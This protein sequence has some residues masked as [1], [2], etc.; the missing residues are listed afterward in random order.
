MN[1]DAFLQAFNRLGLAQWEGIEEDLAWGH[2][3]CLMGLAR[4]STDG[5][6]YIYRAPVLPGRLSPTRVQLLV[7]TSSSPLP[8]LSD[9]AS[10][11]DDLADPV[12]CEP[13][14]LISLDTSRGRS[15]NRELHHPCYILVD[16]RAFRSFGFRPHGVIEVVLGQDE[17]SF[18]TVLPSAVNVVSLGEFLAPLMPTGLPGLQWQ[19]WM[20]G[21][22]VTLDLIE[23]QEGFFLQVQVWCGLT[24]MQNMG[25]AAPLITGTLH[26]DMDAMIDT[27]LVRVTT[28]IPGGNTLCSSRVLSV[29]C[30][31]TMQE[32]CTLGELRSRFRDLREVDFRL[33]LAHPV[34]IWHEPILTLNR[35]RMVLRYEDV[36]LR[37]DAVV[38]LR[39]HLPPYKGEGAIYCP[40]VLRKRELLAQLGISISSGECKCYANGA[41]L[42]DGV[43]TEV[44]DGDVI[45]CMCASPDMGHE[46]ETLS[47]GSCSDGSEV[48]ITAYHST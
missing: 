25:V 43:E 48:E 15:R 47:I 6:I 21:E 7:T 41:E 1:L 33:I 8:L 34:I 28:Y 5:P 24:L 38:L 31:R 29:I 10:Q 46:I 26:F 20:N 23:C 16:F 12:Q 13:W 27:S 2:A 32:T 35:E 3:T 37:L 14:R 19:A 17:F 11:F 40:R 9:L 22:L 42:T 30:P 18:P 36:V 39:L 44:E 4:P 45:R